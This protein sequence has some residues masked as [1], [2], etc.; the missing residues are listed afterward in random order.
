MAN[1]NRVLIEPAR[2]DLEGALHEAVQAANEKS[3]LRVLRWPLDAAGAVLDQVEGDA[4]GWRQWNGGD[5]GRGGETRSAAVLAWWTDLIGRKHCRVVGRRGNLD[6]ARLD[7]LLCP[8]GEPRPALWLVY[9]DYFIT[10]RSKDR[11]RLIALCSCGSFGVPEDIG[12]MG[13]CCGACHDRREEGRSAVAA[14]P[15]PR[16]GTLSGHHGHL[17][18]LTW[19]PDGRIIATGGEPGHVKLWDA[20]T[21]RE[22]GTLAEDSEEWLLGAAF[23]PDGSAVFTGSNRGTVKQWDV[24]TGVPL[25]S[26]SAD[27]PVMY[28]AL[29]PNGE[30]VA[31]ANDR[32]VTLRE[33]ATGRLRQDWRGGLGDV[34]CLAFAPDGAS[35]ACGSRQGTVK[36]WDVS[37]GVERARLDRPGAGIAGL[38][39]TP[40]RQ[41]VAVAL[42][43]PGPGARGAGPDDACAVLLWGV[44]R[45]HVR[46]ALPGHAGGT[47]CVDFAPDGRILA[48]G[49]HDRAVTLW[50]VNAGQERVSLEWHL[51]SVCAVAFSPDGQTLATASF[52]GTAKLWPREALTP[53]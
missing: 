34:S 27:G 21:G 7:N 36:V 37:R 12:W 25:H 49:G 38:A 24:G 51:D 45:H 29:A 22:C 11:R 48:S 1:Y 16:R 42:Q 33:S 31:C 23:S 18:F 4:E 40:D 13:N 39:F 50:D 2:E 43:P 41:T 19:S 20:V 35:L 9:P 26:F 28:L 32:G 3:R 6:R 53:V 5:P 52:D 46:A 15:D 14:W 17:F 8:E 44:Q 47:R 10:K 30:W